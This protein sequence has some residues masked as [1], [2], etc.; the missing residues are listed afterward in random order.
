MYISLAGH[1]QWRRR[2]LR[3]RHLAAAKAT[4]DP[5]NVLRVNQNIEPSVPV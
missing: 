2:Q 4:Y 1:A 3:R 5:T